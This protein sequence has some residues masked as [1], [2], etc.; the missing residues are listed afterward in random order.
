MA[1]RARNSLKSNAAVLSGKA[2]RKP[3]A[4]ESP[5]LG[6]GATRP[7]K[8]RSS[9]TV[10][11]RQR[12]GGEAG[13]E[14]RFERGNKYF[15]DSELK[16]AITEFTAVI[17]D[18]NAPADG[19]ANARVNRGVTY[20]Q[21]G[22]REKA[23]ADYTAVI[24]AA[25]SPLA[26][27][28]HA[29][30][31]R[32]NAYLQAG[33]REKAI[34][35]YTAVVDDPNTTAEQRANARVNRGVAHGQG[36]EWE[37]EI[38]ECTAVIDDP[39]TP[40]E[41]RA[42][43]RVNRGIAYGA[44]GER[45]KQIADYTA[46]ID[47][48]NS[49]GDL[50]AKARVNRGAAYGQAGE[51]E[52]E[53]A[54]HTAVIDD[55][56]SPGK[57]RAMARFNR[58]VNY[59]NVREPGKALVDLKALIADEN[60]PPEVRGAARFFRGNFVGPDKESDSTERRINRVEIDGYRPFRRFSADLGALTVI[61]GANGAGKTSLFDFLRF[62]GRVAEHPMPANIDERS[63]G[64]R[65]F[66]VGG[67]ER[68]D[69][70][71]AF[72]LGIGVPLRYEAEILGPIG[73]PS[74]PRERLATTDPVPVISE[75]KPYVFLEFL[76]GKGKIV[77]QKQPVGEAQPWS[78]GPNEL[79]IRRAVDPTMYVPPRAR[80]YFISWRFYS[81]FEIDT[82]PRAEIR[83]PTMSE[84]S[85][86]PP[87]LKTNG[88]NLSAIL[89]CLQL[90][91][92]DAWDELQTHLRST[93]PGFRSLMVKPYGG[94]GTVMGFWRE[95]GVEDEFTLADFSDGMLRFLC[96]AVICLSPSPPPLV[97]IDE[98]EVGLHPRMLPVVAGLFEAASARTQFIIATHSPEFLS[99]FNLKDLAVLRKEGATV[100]FVRPASS[101]VLEEMVKELGG[102]GIARSHVSGEMEALP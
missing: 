30:F 18:A 45:E 98:P 100:Q 12:S 5:S 67:A 43:A 72:D 1:K 77:N 37:K 58:G 4:A 87:E 57:Q 64:K 62:V 33:N 99:H 102:E 23:I 20:G 15:A 46:V 79:A 78:L 42:D 89:N 95:E 59:V 91:D 75:D 22:E 73:R 41:Q 97:C 63:A 101:R 61:V 38:A 6:S 39:T 27:R 88:S 36:G 7:A 81:G 71:L 90:A 11:E 85:D 2:G 55:P 32:G 24:D 70:A 40:A 47:D 19:R 28:A 76:G 74:V 10:I 8:A 49:A 96:W 48:P 54:D 92:Q 82:G 53:I 66:H 80:D 17:D 56:R 35:D 83:R 68:I 93:I 86:P 84:P 51:R 44:A 60:A 94:P 52:K 29:R 13:A 9:I 26:A 69:F 50:R 16:K 3:R 14:D 25:E 65:L 21:A 31:N 34:V